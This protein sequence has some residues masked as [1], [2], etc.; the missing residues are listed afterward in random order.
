MISV[1][2]HGA[3]IM[4]Y[5]DPKKAAAYAREWR[6]K[7]ADKVRADDSERRARERVKDPSA[8]TQKMR[9][10]RAANPEKAKAQ[11]DKGNK[12]YKLKLKTDPVFREKERQRKASYLSIPEVRTRRRETWK[13]WAKSSRINFPARHRG[14]ALRRMYGLSPEQYDAMVEAQRSVCYL[15]DK[16]SWQ[17]A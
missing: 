3:D 2:Q 13:E 14:H 15:W 6:A 12:R 11:A 17:Q 4:G 9:E 5:T 1:N 8:A 16:R 10:W 7:H